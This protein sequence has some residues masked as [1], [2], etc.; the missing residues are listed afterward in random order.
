MILLMASVFTPREPDWLLFGVVTL[1]AF[2]IGFWCFWM[3]DKYWP[4]D[5]E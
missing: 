4:E 3:V 1:A 2:V 5:R